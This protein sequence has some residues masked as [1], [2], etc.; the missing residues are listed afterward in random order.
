[1]GLAAKWGSEVLV[2]VAFHCMCCHH[3]LPHAPVS[4]LGVP[5]TP[6]SLSCNPCIS[7]PSC[8]GPVTA[9][10]PRTMAWSLQSPYPLTCLSPGAAGGI[11]L[12][13]QCDPCSS[14]HPA[15]TPHTI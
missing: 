6:V 5:D 12:K 14:E 2:G 13:G 3:P 9:S 11:P 10:A 15:G 1:M 8:L 4:D 7:T